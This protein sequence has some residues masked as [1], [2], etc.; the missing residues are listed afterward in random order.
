MAEKFI[1]H[2]TNPN[3]NPFYNHSGAPSEIPLPTNKDSWLALV[4]AMSE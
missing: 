4:H 1:Q 2:S 3:S